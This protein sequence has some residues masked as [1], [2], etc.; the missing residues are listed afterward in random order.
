MKAKIDAAAPNADPIAKFYALE[1]LSKLLAPEERMQ[2]QMYMMQNREALQLGLAQMRIDAANARAADT[3][4]AAG[5][6]ADEAGWQFI[7]KPDGSIVRANTR[8]GQV[9]P[10]TLDPGSGKMGQTA[11]PAD[12]SEVDYWSRVL[13]NG[14][15]LPP[16]LSR[17]PTGSQLV[18]AI[19][20]DMAKKGSMPQGM[21]PEEF[22]ANVATVK[23]DDRSL[24][25]MTKMAD[26]ATSF[27]RTASQNFDLALKLSKDAVPTDL[28]PF[29]NR[30][31]ES[32]QTQFGDLNVPPY[33]TAM[34]TGANEYAK[35][36]S[37]STGAQGSTVDSRR[38]AAELFSPY[39]SSGQIERVVAVAKADMGNRKQSL[40]GQIDDIK[41]R[42]R[43]AGSKTPTATQGQPGAPPA[44]ATQSGAPQPAQQGAAP[45]PGDVVDGYRFKGGNPADQTNWERVQ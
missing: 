14:G 33:V 22:I 38:E 9:Q 1:K 34:L 20:A 23:A 43:S 10:T 4:A 15:H 7:T 11:K 21:T 41:G 28:G 45:K 8:T 29:F 6:R 19:M 31:V 13:Q 26:A 36:M 2:M 27:E 5:S 30:W 3:R 35:I 18:Q 24:S 12:Q 25:N 16:G 37:G 32:G 40:Y 17:T 44:P 42:L 39:L